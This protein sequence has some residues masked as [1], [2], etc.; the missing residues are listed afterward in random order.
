MAAVLVKDF[1]PTNNV[2][3]VT[4]KL[5]LVVICPSLTPAVIVALPVWLVAGVTVTIR[6][7]PLPPNTMLF[8]GTSVGFEDPALKVRLVKGVSTSPIVKLNGPVEV[9]TLIVWL[10]IPVIVGG[11]FTPVTVTTR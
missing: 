11:S 7:A 6:F 2:P 10:A 3:T 9:F 4:T 5:V 8:A 1:V